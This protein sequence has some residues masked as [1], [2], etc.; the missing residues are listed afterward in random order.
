MPIS[1][2][3]LEKKKGRGLWVEKTHH[4]SLVTK[5]SLPVLFPANYV[6]HVLTLCYFTVG[7]GEISPHVRVTP[8]PF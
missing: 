6:F 8:L 1:I 3:R 4:T 5:S 7:F 2:R